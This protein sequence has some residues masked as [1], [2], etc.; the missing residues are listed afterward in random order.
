ME[1]RTLRDRYEHFGY[2]S[3]E[4]SATQL[5]VRSVYI[6]AGVVAARHMYRAVQQWQDDRFNNL[7]LEPPAPHIEQLEPV[8]VKGE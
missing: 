7:T 3:H 8:E 6:A 5:V 2:L 1:K 4:I